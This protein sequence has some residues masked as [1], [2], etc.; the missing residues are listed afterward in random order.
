[1]GDYKAPAFGPVGEV[2]RRLDAFDRQQREDGRASG[3]QTA[4]AL[5]QLTALVNDL[6]AEIAAVSASGATWYGPV[7][8]TGT[9]QADT[10]LTSVGVYNL[11]VSTLPGGRRTDWVHVSGAIG[12]APSSIV[13]KMD[14]AEVPFTAA[15]VLAIAPFVFHYKA[16]VAIRDD[17]ENPNYDPTYEVPWDI[18]LIAEHLVTHGLELFVFFEDDGVTPAGINYDMFAAV[19][20]LV[21][22]RDQQTQLDDLRRRLDAAGI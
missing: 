7:T 4:E 18:G 6:A 13:K 11:D 2:R 12:Y 3:T 14:L 1:M 21:V 10:G 22:V 9:V 15:D 5:A 8:T 16:Q 17:P 19:A 20:L